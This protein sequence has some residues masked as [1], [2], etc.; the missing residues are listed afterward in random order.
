MDGFDHYSTE[1]LTKKGWTLQGGTPTID[2]TGGVD[3]GGCVKLDYAE[4]LRYDMG[5]V[6]GTKFTF[7]MAI[8]FEALANSAL[9]KLWEIENDIGGSYFMCQASSDG[10]IEIWN[11]GIPGKI[12]DS[13]TGFYTT[14][15]WYYLELQCEIANGAAGYFEAR[16]NNVVLK[17]QSGDNVWTGGSNISHIHYQG[18]SSS[19]LRLDNF[20]LLDENGSK[21]NDFLGPCKVN[22]I[23][24][25][26]AGNYAQLTGVIGANYANVDE[27]QLGGDDY[28][29]GNT[30]G[31]KDSYA[32]PALDSE[33]PDDIPGIQVNAGAE[34]TGDN[35][36]QWRSLIRKSST[37]YN[38]T[39]QD[40]DKGDINIKTEVHE[41]DPSDSSDWDKSKVDACEFGVELLNS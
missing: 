25:N 31:L 24:P 40:L 38:G 32:Y 13:G 23:L 7:G 22:T 9:R 21:N 12:W 2:L 15:Q 30:S 20:Y 8:Y 28:N 33:I 16:W 17:T 3:G 37:D 26:G 10:H 27:A 6:G 34:K 1:Y 19:P 18:P 41:T 36:H 29:R 35:S 5:D 4:I 11:N 39:T 14:G